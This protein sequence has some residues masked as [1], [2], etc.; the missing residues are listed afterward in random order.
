MSCYNANRWLT[1]AIDSVLIQTF[2]SFELIIID[3]GSTDNT[4]SIIEQY[5]DKD[6]RIIAIFKENTGL[7]DS[8][9]IGIRRAAGDWIAR[10]DADDLCEPTRFEKQAKL[11]KSNTNL[12]LI[13][14]GCS[15]INE[16]G[17]NLATYS[18]P[19]THD[20]LLRQLHNS[21]KFP[22][23]SSAFYRKDKV[24]AIGGYRSRIK[25]AE[26][27]DLWLRFS[28]IG[29]MACLDDAL[30]MIRQ[31]VGQ[32][33]HDESGRQQLLDSRLA[34]ISYW[35][36][37]NG[38]K[39]PV[40]EVLVSFEAFHLWLRTRLIQEGFFEYHS[41]C[42]SLKGLIRETPKSFTGV[43]RLAGN[44][45]QHPIYSFRFFYRIVFSDNLTRRLALEWLKHK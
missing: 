13:G 36:R 33:S 44:F 10:I 5:L 38:G 7:A 16:Y 32:I 24:L 30:V 37:S 1:Q 19:K 35:I 41:H 9:N 43:F 39:D 18:Y 40:D 26:D 8:L 28:E 31:H 23:H 27:L 14:T 12:V 20:S 3:D 2:K 34:M 6:N 21:R 22:P 42:D 25:R 29:E 11:A 15:L 4:K 45:L 17:A